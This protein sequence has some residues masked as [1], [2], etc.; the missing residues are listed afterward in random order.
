VQQTT[1]IFMIK[2]IEQLVAG[3]HV[4][5]LIE[6]TGWGFNS[7]IVNSAND[8][9]LAI[10]SPTRDLGD[11]M[12][13]R[14]TQLG[15]P[16]YLIAANNVHHLGLSEWKRRYPE[17]QIVAHSTA[18]ARLQKFYPDLQFNSADKVS[19]P[20][21]T[22]VAPEGLKDGEIWLCTRNGWIVGDAFFNVRPPVSGFFGFILR[23]TGTAPGFRIGNFWAP[24]H[25]KSREQY[26]SWLLRELERAAPE[27]LVPA[28]GDPV[29]GDNLV[30]RLRAMAK[31]K[32]S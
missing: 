31:R 27:W 3:V 16:K 9:D 26:Y 8:N 18:I 6:K 23:M 20:G 25:V 17:S 2:R 1:G 12:H 10:Y 30:E 13:A 7:A 24:L 14:I 21:V 32:Y 15:K 19:I 4:I 29:T 22:I 28:H 11:D 5:S